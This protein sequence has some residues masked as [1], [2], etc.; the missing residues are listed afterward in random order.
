MQPLALFS[1][2]RERFHY[3]IL[4]SIVV[5]RNMT[6]VNWKADHFF[7][8]VPDLAMVMVGEL[9]VDWL[10]HAFITKFNEIPAEVYKGE[11][12]REK[13]CRVD[14]WSMLRLLELLENKLR[15]CFGETDAHRGLQIMWKKTSAPFMSFSFKIEIL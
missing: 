8:M 2:V 5:V 4:L 6:A 10:K 12:V 7:E 14:V 11:I 15:L 9:I 13:Y 3:V 1:D